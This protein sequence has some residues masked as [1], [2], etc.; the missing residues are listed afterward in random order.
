MPVILGAL[1]ERA[2]GETRVSLV[3]EIVTKFTRSGARVVMERGAGERSNFPDRL[4]Q[5]VEWAEAVP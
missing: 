1:R 5:G 4:Y 3:P 2:T